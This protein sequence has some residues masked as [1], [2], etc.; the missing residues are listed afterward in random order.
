M[1]FMR[2]HRSLCVCLLSAAVFAAPLCLAQSQ[3]QRPE[4]KKEEKKAENDKKP[5][6]AKS[7]KKTP[8]LAELSRQAKSRPKDG[9]PVYTNAVFQQREVGRVGSST[10]PPKAAAA[11]GATSADGTA[12]EGEAEGEASVEQITA[13]IGIARAEYINAVNQSHVLQLKMNDLR[14]RYLVESDGATQERFEAMLNQVTEEIAAADKAIAEQAQK[15]DALASRATTAGMTPGAVRDLI[16]KLPSAKK[17]I[18][19]DSD[20]EQR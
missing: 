14:N 18:D 1:K 9:V 15:L 7:E 6:T 11:G 17:I 16:G 2:L 12:A 4:Q 19:D 20:G 3:D 5:E 8:S 10:T 13:E